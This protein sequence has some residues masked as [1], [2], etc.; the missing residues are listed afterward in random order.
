MFYGSKNNNLPLKS[1]QKY[2]Y[3]II[4]GKGCG[5]LP[6]PQTA[7]ALYK[8]NS[9]TPFLNYFLQTSSIHQS[10]FDI[11]SYMLEQRFLS[12]FIFNYFRDLQVFFFY[13]QVY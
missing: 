7:Q 2:S 8:E 9:K 13:Q 4:I 3:P 6:Q 10:T 1:Q 11:K 12:I 5:G